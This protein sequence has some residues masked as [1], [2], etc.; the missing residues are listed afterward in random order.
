MTSVVICP[1]SA[2][3]ESKLANNTATGAR[4]TSVT[5]P[6]MPIGMSRSVCG[7]DPWPP[8]RRARDAA[9]AERNPS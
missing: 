8:V 5:I 9:M 6:T 7:K 1:L 3:P 4:Q 2:P